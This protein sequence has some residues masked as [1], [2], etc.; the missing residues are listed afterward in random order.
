MTTT[1]ETLLTTVLERLDNIDLRLVELEAQSDIEARDRRRASA[2]TNVLLFNGI[3]VAA[4]AVDAERGER[5]E[6]DAALEAKDAA[7]DARIS[8][9]SDEKFNA[10]L[11]ACSRLQA[12]EKACG[13]FDGEPAAPAYPPSRPRRPQPVSVVFV[14]VVSDDGAGQ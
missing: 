3:T 4:R 14:P 8:S 11:D 13:F 10:Y 2:Q 7:L 9:E 12:L 1:L 5:I 6:A